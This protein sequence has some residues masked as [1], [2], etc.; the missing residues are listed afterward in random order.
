MILLFYYL[1]FSLYYHCY[2][3]KAAQ[4]HSVNNSGSLR[5]TNEPVS[6][7]PTAAS[8]LSAYIINLQFFLLFQICSKYTKGYYTLDKG[9][10]T[11][12]ELRC[13][14]DIFLCLIPS[15]YSQICCPIFQ[16]RAF[17]THTKRCEIDH[18]IVRSKPVRFRT[19]ATKKL[20]S[21]VLKNV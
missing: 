13:K 6:G 2:L 10:P 18:R 8:K 3:K 17:E 9:R 5:Q 7:L 12:L 19:H 14:Q 16:W 4:C 1:L 11:L 20:A 15:M 21:D